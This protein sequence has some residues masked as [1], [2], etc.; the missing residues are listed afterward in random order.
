MRYALV[1]VR[2]LVCPPEGGTCIRSHKT[3]FTHSRVLQRAGLGDGLGGWGGDK[4]HVQKGFGFSSAPP[5][6]ARG[7]KW[8]N[9]GSLTHSLRQFLH[10]GSE[11][12]GGGVGSCRTAGCRDTEARA[13]VV[14]L[15]PSSFFSVFR[16]F[17]LK[18]EFGQPGSGFGLRKI[19]KGAFGVTWGRCLSFG[20]RHLPRLP[21]CLTSPRCQTVF[22]GGGAASSFGTTSGVALG[23]P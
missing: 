15:H 3:E 19:K 11:G 10:G 18:I 23:G 5:K 6:G 12:N 8:I 9:R 4:G 13:A 16:F 17:G 22:G 20:S 7:S 21:Q 2:Y 14:S 1:S